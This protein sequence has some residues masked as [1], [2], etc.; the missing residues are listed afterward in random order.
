MSYYVYMMA[1][2][3]NGVLYIGITN[4][5]VRRI[6]EHKTS[7]ARGF[8]SRYN[9]TLLVWF[10]MYDDPLTAISR[11]K[12]LKKW[13]REWKIKLIEANN[14]DWRDLYAAIV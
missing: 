1:S 13:R 12:E 5:L 11:E 14:A 6:H 10:E 4:D 2:K 9:V 8:T 7:S 3:K